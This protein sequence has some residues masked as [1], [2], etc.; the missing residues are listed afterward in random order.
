M[1]L[2]LL[3]DRTPGFPRAW[4]VGRPHLSSYYLLVL[5][6]GPTVRPLRSLVEPSPSGCASSREPRLAAWCRNAL[7]DGYTRPRYHAIP[8]YYDPRYVLTDLMGV[9]RISS[10]WA[11]Q[12]LDWT[13]PILPFNCYDCLWLKH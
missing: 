8:S 7:R 5:P 2:N 10:Q 3:T 4:V 12:R 13:N 1:I 6:V 11:S 9:V